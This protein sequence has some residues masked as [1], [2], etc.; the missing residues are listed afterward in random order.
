MRD[1]QKAKQC[2]VMLAPLL[3]K[4]TLKYAALELWAAASRPQLGPSAEA[5][6][7]IANWCKPF[8]HPFVAAVT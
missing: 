3:I 1:S 4:V 7:I 5:P 6:L 8:P 2:I